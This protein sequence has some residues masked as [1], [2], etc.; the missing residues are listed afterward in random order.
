MDRDRDARLDE[1]RRLGG[2]GWAHVAAPEPRPPT[3]DREER[4]VDVSGQRAH[5][6]E[7]AGVAG[8]ERAPSAVDDVGQALARA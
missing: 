4:D 1:R 3:R 2:L 6:V 5:P 8:E 7:Q